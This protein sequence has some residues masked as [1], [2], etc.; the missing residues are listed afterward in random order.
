MHWSRSSQVLY[1]E[2]R[3]PTRGKTKGLWTD[4]FKVPHSHRK[5]LAH[6]LHSFRVILPHL[7]A[8]WKQW[9]TLVLYVAMDASCCASPYV[10]FC[11]TK[12]V[13]SHSLNGTMTVD[14]KSSWLSTTGDYATVE[15]TKNSSSFCSA[16]H[17]NIWVKMS[18]VL[19]HR[20]R[21]N[22]NEMRQF[23]S[24]TKHCNRAWF[25]MTF[26]EAGVH[27]KLRRQRQLTC[28]LSKIC[29]AERTKALGALIWAYKSVSLF[30]EG[31]SRN[32]TSVLQQAP[33]KSRA[34]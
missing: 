3:N 31:Q 34:C 30:S 27:G 32:S 5:W 18:H 10:G 9:K 23:D 15:K 21:D 24:C 16:H 11:K 13:F 1:W 20:D 8:I 7:V 17:K 25:R 19:R 4:V 22:C 29:E 33:Q 14:R 2:G 26:G 6:I 28:A 12:F